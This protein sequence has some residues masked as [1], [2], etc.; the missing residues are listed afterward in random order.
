VEARIEI[1][2]Q[3]KASD[4]AFILALEPLSLLLA[5]YARKSKSGNDKTSLCLFFFYKNKN[6]PRPQ[7]AEVS[8]RREA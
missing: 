7:G 2:G 6:Q 3:P 5:A 1:R 8:H 4:A